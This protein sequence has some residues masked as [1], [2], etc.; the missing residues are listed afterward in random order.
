MKG[1][2]QNKLKIAT[3]LSF[4]CLLVPFSIY[5]LWIYV[6]NLGTTQTERV[7]AFK[8]YFPDF[9]TDR[10]SSTLLGIT[11]CIFAIIFSSISLK[12]SGKF[13]KTLNILIIV[14]S[15]LMLLLNLFSM[16]QLN[17]LKDHDGDK[18]LIYLFFGKVFLLVFYT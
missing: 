8:N 16:M 4:I 1:L 9:L 3:L 7:S 17:I 11:F 14:V 10:L 12:L 5:G 6:F 15:S 13:W 18:K 2:T